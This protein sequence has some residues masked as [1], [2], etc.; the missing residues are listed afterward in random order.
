MADE[1]T[2]ESEMSQAVHKPGM[3]SVV[4]RGGTPPPDARDADG[5]RTAGRPTVAAGK[6][7]PFSV[8]GD[9]PVKGSSSS[10]SASPA[11]GARGASEPSMGNKSGGDLLQDAVDKDVTG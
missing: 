5:N 4:N 3:E 8:K 2:Y 1:T 7:D 11:G 6:T 9:G 10:S